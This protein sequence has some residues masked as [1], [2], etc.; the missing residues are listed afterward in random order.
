MEEVEAIMVKLPANTQLEVD[1]DK[2]A[3]LLSLVN[4]EGEIPVCA[5]KYITI[6]AAA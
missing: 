4:D 2:L 1:T 3:W 6:V 5:L